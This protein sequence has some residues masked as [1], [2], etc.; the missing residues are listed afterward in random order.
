MP[1]A[2]A[3]CRCH[4]GGEAAAAQE[5]PAALAEDLNLQ[6]AGASVLQ[7]IVSFKQPA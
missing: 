3:L 7:C 6:A 2:T 1:T 4:A 5:A